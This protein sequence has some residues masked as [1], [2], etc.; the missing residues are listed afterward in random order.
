MTQIQLHHSTWTCLKRK[1]PMVGLN[2]LFEVQKLLTRNILTKGKSV[3]HKAFNNICQIMEFLS[4]SSQQSL[5]SAIEPKLLQWPIRS[6]RILPNCS[7]LLAKCLSTSFPAKTQTLSLHPNLLTSPTRVVCLM[8]LMHA[9]H[10]PCPRAF[11]HA[12]VGQCAPVSTWHTSLLALSLFSK[13]TS[14]LLRPPLTSLNKIG[15]PPP[16]SYTLTLLY[17]FFPNSN[18]HL[19]YY[20][21]A[22]TFIIYLLH[23]ECELPQ[24]KNVVFLFTSTSPEPTRAPVPK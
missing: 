22:C 3:H 19:T 18:Q 17:Y 7:S 6:H 21:L 23:L 12:H 16:F 8:F 1:T 11:T 4:Q 24:S 13:A 2:L 14:L 20:I 9:N 15:T 10:G 5:S